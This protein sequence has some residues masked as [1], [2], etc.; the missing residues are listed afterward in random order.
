MTRPRASWL[1]SAIVLTALPWFSVAHIFEL[2]NKIAMPED[3]YFG[4][5]KIYNGW[6]MVRFFLP[7]AFFANLALA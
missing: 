2:F 5:Q 4:A 6:W 7:A 1:L 3:E